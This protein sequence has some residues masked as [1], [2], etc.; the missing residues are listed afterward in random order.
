MKKIDKDKTYTC[1]FKD[2]EM[3]FI[4]AK[5]LLVSWTPFEI[6]QMKEKGIYEEMA[7][8]RMFTV[9]Q[10]LGLYDRIKNEDGHA[11]GTWLEQ[12]K[13]L[14]AEALSYIDWNEKKGEWRR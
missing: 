11:S 14:D 9:Y 4:H 12:I 6:G 10:L 5:C 3:F 2:E 8:R 1:R 13:E 7:N